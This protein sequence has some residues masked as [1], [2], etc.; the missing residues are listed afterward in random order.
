M[1]NPK[2][3]IRYNDILKNTEGT[4]ETD[5]SYDDITE[6]AKYELSNLTSWTVESI[7][8]DG[9]GAML[10]TYSM[11]ED[12]PLYVMIPNEETANNAKAK[13]KEYLQ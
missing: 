3:M 7:S 2:Y 9:E 10:P 6:L 1:T 13:I 8:L 11:G 5:I 4:I 12:L